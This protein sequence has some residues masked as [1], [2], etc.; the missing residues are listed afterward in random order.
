M[1]Q[2]RPGTARRFVLI[3]EKLRAQCGRGL[4]NSIVG[5]SWENLRYGV[6]PPPS[7]FSVDDQGIEWDGGTVSG[8]NDWPE[9][10]RLG[11]WLLWLGSFQSSGAESRSCA[12]HCRALIGP[13]PNS[14]KSALVLPSPP[15]VTCQGTKTG[16]QPATIRCSGSL[17]RL[18]PRLPA[19]S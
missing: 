7:L 15:Q 5:V 4:S 18:C 3:N 11:V 6:N 9:P 14:V 1:V 8:R 10:D 17:I 16:C 13:S 12:R 19:F 2:A